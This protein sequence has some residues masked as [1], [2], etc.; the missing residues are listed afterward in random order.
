MKIRQ[1]KKILK[2]VYKTKYWAFRWGY[3]HGKKDLGKIA[4]DHRLLMAMLLAKKWNWRKVQNEAKKMEAKH[5]FNPKELSRSM[6][7]L[8]SFGV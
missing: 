4:G 5:P 6:E 2:Q 3:Y 7:K 8:K 1:A